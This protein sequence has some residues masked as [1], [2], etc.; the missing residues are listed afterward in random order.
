MHLALGGLPPGPLW[1][2]IWVLGP[3]AHRQCL[4][5]SDAFLL[6][7]PMFCCQRNDLFWKEPNSGT[8]PSKVQ[9]GESHCVPV[10]VPGAEKDKICGGS[11]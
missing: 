10:P 7:S 5:R 1:V 6:P 9:E 3:V 11:F 2:G 4:Q 8:S